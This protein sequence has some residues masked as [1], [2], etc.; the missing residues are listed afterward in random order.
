MNQVCL[1]LPVRAG[2]TE[3]AR[4]FL[5]ELDGARRDDYDISE[6]R[7]GISKEVWFLAPTGD[8]ELLIG[9]IESGDFDAAFAQ[10]VRSRD[11]FDRWFKDR[12]EEVTGIDLNDPPEMD[13]P[14]LLSAYEVEAL[15]PA[16]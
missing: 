8:R 2:E 13:L 1:V 15:S 11:E 14:E 6:R 16:S 9:Y 12:L 5:R 10:F 4:T 3:A 7:I